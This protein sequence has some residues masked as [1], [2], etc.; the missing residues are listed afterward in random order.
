VG[1]EDEANDPTEYP[2]VMEVPGEDIQIVDGIKH[3]NIERG[4]ACDPAIIIDFMYKVVNSSMLM[5]LE[6]HSTKGAN[7]LAQVAIPNLEPTY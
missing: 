5:I 6:S 1:S 7:F 4:R 3:L 2:K